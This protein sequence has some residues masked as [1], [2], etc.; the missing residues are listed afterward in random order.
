LADR[1]FTTVLQ[2]LDRSQTSLG[3]TLF[4]MRAL[5]DRAGESYE[6][7]LYKHKAVLARGRLAVCHHL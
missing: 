1:T 3:P 6:D 5:Q 4:I 7:P 2:I